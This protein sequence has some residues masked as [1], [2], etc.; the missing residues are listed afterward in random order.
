MTNKSKLK[1]MFIISLMFLLVIFIQ[2]NTTSTFAENSNVNSTE[3]TGPG[4]PPLVVEKELSNSVIEPG[5]SITVKITIKN[6][7][8]NPVYDITISETL[9]RYAFQYRGLNSETITFNSI[10]GKESR[11]I[12]YIIDVLIPQEGNLTLDSTKVTYYFEQGG[13]SRQQY[14]SIS[15][16]LQ[17]NFVQNISEENDNQINFD[18]VFLAVLLL[19]YSAVILVQS[20]F[21]R[22]IKRN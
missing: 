10:E 17:L 5:Q 22:L 3:Q 8:N 12:F 21:T 18:Y 2:S 11:T 14:T 6:L 4:S 19:I 16:E 1:S 9:L 15:Q 13:E 20:V 7:N